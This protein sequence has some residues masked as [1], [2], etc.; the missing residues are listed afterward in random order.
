MAASEANCLSSSA[1]SSLVT[2]SLNALTYLMRRGS[3]ERGVAGRGAMQNWRISAEA[4]LEGGWR[5]LICHSRTQSNCWIAAGCK[6]KHKV[7]SR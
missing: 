2:Q 6:V 7:S 3:G 4:K 1:C 5:T